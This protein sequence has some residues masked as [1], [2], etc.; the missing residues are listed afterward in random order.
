MTGLKAVND[1]LG[2]SAGDAL[3]KLAAAVMREHLRSYDVIIRVGGDEFVC[4]MS[5]ATLEA[6]HQ[7][8]G[9]I[10]ADA[11]TA[12]VGLKFGIAAPATRG[13]PE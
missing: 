5:G 8:L 12:G 2:H 1:T 13:R 4:V 9:E 3:L 6:A 10:Q 11:A 7:R